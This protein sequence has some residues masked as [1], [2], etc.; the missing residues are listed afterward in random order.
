MKF[1]HTPGP[2][3]VTGYYKHLIGSSLNDK[4]IIGEAWGDRK[5]DTNNMVANTRL[6]AKA[7]EMLEALIDDINMFE[8]LCDLG[9]IDKSLFNK[10]KEIRNKLIKEATG[11]TWEEINE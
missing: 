1:K 2:W 5:D 7:P 10:I 4:I 3:K 8:D 11:L 6:M 9:A